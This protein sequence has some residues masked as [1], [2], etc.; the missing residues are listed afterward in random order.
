MLLTHVFPYD[1]G[2]Q[3]MAIDVT[4]QRN[5]GLFQAVQHEEFPPAAAEDGD[6]DSSTMPVPVPVPASQRARWLDVHK[7]AA[8]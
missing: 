6:G 1:A 5:N 3:T 8:G 4:W 7:P 2:L